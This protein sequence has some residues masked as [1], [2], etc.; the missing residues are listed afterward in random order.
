[1]A[2]RLDLNEHWLFAEEFQEEMV[3]LEYDDSGMQ[4]VRLPHTV[5]ETPFHY[6]DESI[7]QKI[8]CYRNRF[9]VPNLWK[10]K[11]VRLTF[12]G[13]AHDSTVFLNGAQIAEHH[14]G[15]TAF[16]V[17]IT[18]HLMLEEEN[19]LVVRLDSR[20]SLNVPP[21]GYM[22]DYM[23]YGGLYREV[24]LD[25]SDQI[26]MEDV[27]LRTEG[28]I[29]VPTLHT[30]VEVK[31][32]E[33][34]PLMIRQYLAIC[35]N[36]EDRQ[37]E[38]VAEQKNL[39]CEYVV[40]PTSTMGSKD[41]LQILDFQ[42]EVAQ[43]L[44][45][46][47]QHPNLYTVHMQLLNAETKE[48]YDEKKV[49][50]GF[51]FSV[52]CED[53]YYLNGEKLK[54]RGLDRHQCYPYVGYAMPASMQVLDA[55]I[56]K[57]ELG[58][59]AVRTSHYPQSQAFMDACDALGLLVFTEIPGWQHIG[60][61]EWKAQAVKNTEDM[62]RQYR[63]HPSVILWGVRINESV[64]DDAFYART[65]EVAHRL[66]PSRPT[67][68][69][70]A[71]KK[72]HLLEDVYTYNDFQHDG[73]AKGCAPK[74]KVTSDVMKP[75]LITE[76]N[77]HMYPTKV[78]D[79]EE[80]RREHAIRHANVLDAV[81]G[82]EDIAGSFGWCMF[83]YN[84]HKDFGSGDRIC[85]HGVMDMFRNPKMAASIYACQQEESPVLELSSSMDIGEHPGSNRGD[86]W[87]FT[88]AD[89]VKMYKNDCL[90]KE[91]FPVDS[92]YKH[93]K[94]GPILV[95]EFVGDALEAEHFK[96]GQAAAVKEILNLTALR[97]MSKLP[98]RVYLLAAKVILL[99]HMN[100]GDA[101]RLF[102][103]YVGDWGQ[104]ATTYRLEAIRGGKV[105]KTLTKGPF[106]KAH[107]E[108]WVDHRELVEARTYDVAAIRFRMVDE[109]GNLLPY[110]DEPVQME[111]TGPIELI[112][113]RVVPLRGGMGGAYVRTMGGMGAAALKLYTAQNEEIKI[114]FT[115]RKHG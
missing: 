44:L 112:G 36:W 101:V 18:E 110:Y 27:F 38:H 22:I 86:I 9:V 87:I 30:T 3:A 96:P 34:K 59:N 37:D 48:L 113:P 15:Y 62:V 4:H 73:K 109:A 72:S 94:H 49:Q 50:F 78:F 52:F 2:R 74:K 63:N 90:L 46:S 115:V 13:A 98:P 32:A 81:A 82:E 16:T 12:E 95:D 35:K 102:S 92:P 31:G 79:D 42:T 106:T 99:Y 85:Y 6:F 40:P 51:R 100:Y 26:Y 57:E 64:D 77:G 114:P 14:C 60:D 104:S 111:V 108:V 1:M 20:E 89:S 66:D 29:D 70:R 10:G 91:Y 54:I 7:Y 58:L 97:G 83:D 21:F 5:A 41:A 55:K 61:D 25:I 75:Y 8:S 93:L 45:W 69:V 17:D 33:G 68:G 53:G 103:K 47:T 56:L 39:I 19:V 80:H 43:V 11:R 107:L 76:Y 67:G 23:T 65:N 71:H 88:N 84:T 105:V 24:Y 28:E